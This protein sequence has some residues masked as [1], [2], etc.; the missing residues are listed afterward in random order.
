MGENKAA[1]PVLKIKNL[2]KSF[3]GTLALDHID[4]DI[5]PGEIH[6]LL[7]ENGAGKSTLIKILD[8]VYTCTAGEF[9]LKGHPYHVQ[10]GGLPIS[11]IHQDLGVVDDLT[12]LENIA[13][14]SGY[15]KRGPFINW[16][17]TRKKAGKI[18]EFMGCD[19]DLDSRVG[20]L[21]S[22]ERSMVA[23]SRALAVESDVL[24]LDE[25]TA[26]LPQNDVEKLFE[27]LRNL[28]NSGMAVIYVSHRLDEVFRIAD[29]VTVLRNGKNISCRPISEFTRE[30]LIFDIVG[31]KTEEVFSTS[32]IKE[33]AEIVMDVQNLCCDFVQDV[34]FQLYKGEIL[35]LFGLRGAG[36]HETGRALYG[37]KK[38]QSLSLTIAG[39]EITLKGCD[40]ALRKG[41]GFLSSKRLEES[42]APLLS[43]RENVYFNPAAN[44][45]HLLQLM[46]H[47]DERV[48]AQATIDRFR[49]KPNNTEN[50]VGTLSGGNQQKVVLSRIF[51]TDPNVFIMEEPT[52][53]VDIGAKTD[54]YLKM[55]EAIASG[56][57]IIM[58]SSDIE[59]VSRISHRVLVFSRGRIC[60]E[61]K[62]DDLNVETLTRYASY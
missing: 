38:P 61:L 54:I 36:H 25:P 15:V 55:N 48:K 58:I 41:I 5:Y 1:A 11:V 42:L 57:S 45:Y 52:I 19:I 60:K 49:V 20:E 24:I 40:D 8:G 53:G 13:V 51:E 34:S 3:S 43:V 39:K 27:I 10:D 17:E 2:C 4:M 35:T 22:A 50:L 59:E 9:I 32:S 28:R 33:N 56:K 46:N 62:H 23:I 31:K 6:A 12:V 21:P 44:G 14:V 29:R 37:C 30:Q 16:R 47:K 18:L 26:T 7:G